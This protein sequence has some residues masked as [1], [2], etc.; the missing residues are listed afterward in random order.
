MGQSGAEFAEVQFGQRS[1]Y[2]HNKVSGGGGELGMKTEDFVDLAAEVVSFNGFG[3]YFCAD[4]NAKAA[5]LGVL[6]WRLPL[7]KVFDRELAISD[8]STFF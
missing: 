7:R 5:F 4:D 6:A 3:I 8:F 1:L 2:D